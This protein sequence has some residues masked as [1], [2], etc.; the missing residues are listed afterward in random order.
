VQIAKV[1]GVSATYLTDGES[2]SQSA[3][4]LTPT[5]AEGL[6]M[7]QAK[8]GLALTFGVS[9]EAIEITIRG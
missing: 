7:A 4:M 1:L 3:E 9:P 5:L 6:T 2:E 8:K